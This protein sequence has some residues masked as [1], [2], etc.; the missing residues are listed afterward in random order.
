MERVNSSPK[1]KIALKHVFKYPY[2][3]DLENHIK[4]SG[5]VGST[6][7]ALPQL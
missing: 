1:L 4:M 3:R 7:Y 5:G 2:K 6:W